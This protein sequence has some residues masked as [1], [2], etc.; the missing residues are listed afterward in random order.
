MVESGE[1]AAILIAGAGSHSSS[2]ETLIDLFSDA[3]RLAAFNPLP[4]V[5]VHGHHR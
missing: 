5:D 3:M 1:R 2:I 4:N